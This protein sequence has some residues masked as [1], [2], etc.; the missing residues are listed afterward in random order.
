MRPRDHYSAAY[1]IPGDVVDLDGE[2][3]KIVATKRGEGW[4]IHFTASNPDRIQRTF[5]ARPDQLIEVPFLARRLSR[6]ESRCA[7][8]PKLGYQRTYRI[9]RNP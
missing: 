6:Y 7:G 9:R 3:W 1:L 2:L 5:R 4:L 8:L